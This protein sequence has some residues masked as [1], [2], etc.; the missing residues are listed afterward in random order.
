MKITSYKKDGKILYKFNAYLGK[1]PLTGKEIRTNR[2]GFLTKK[3][4]EI[5][6]LNLK[7][8]ELSLDKPRATPSKRF[9]NCG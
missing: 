4:A 5:A 3:D 7:T 1:D 6:Y 2:Q 9:M 8:S